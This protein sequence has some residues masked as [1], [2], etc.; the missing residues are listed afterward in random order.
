MARESGDIYFYSP[1]QLDGA[2]GFPN[3]RNLYVY[4]NGHPAYVATL[5]SPKAAVERI[6]VSP[7]GD[8]MAFITKTAADAP[9][10]TPAMPRC[11][12]YDP[13]EADADV[14]LVRPE[15]RRRRRPT[16]KAARTASS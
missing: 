11:T 3:K 9:T 7:D 14:R 16:S 8:H 12:L 10:T 13:A 4:R 1:E 15:R 5:E 6:N 2:R